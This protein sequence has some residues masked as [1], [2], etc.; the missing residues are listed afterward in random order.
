LLKQTGFL[1]AKL[2]ISFGSADVL[3]HPSG[4]ALFYSEA[5]ASVKLLRI[6]K[7]SMFNSLG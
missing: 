7:R 3:P 6:E 1:H 4:N 5:K 2:Y